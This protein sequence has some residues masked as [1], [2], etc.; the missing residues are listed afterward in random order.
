[1]SVIF[2]ITGLVV[3]TTVTFCVAEPTLPD[4]STAV[5]VTVVSPNGNVC[6]ASFVMDEISELSVTV[7][8]PNS[9]TF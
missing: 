6:G 7:G 3:S 2:V 9:I 4:K 1:M 8:S 5:Q